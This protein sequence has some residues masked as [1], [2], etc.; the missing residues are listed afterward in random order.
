[1][2]VG[3]SG[4]FLLAE[5]WRQGQR[6][7]RIPMALTDWY[8]HRFRSLYYHEFQQLNFYNNLQGYNNSMIFLLHNIRLYYITNSE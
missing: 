4:L 8:G 2:I 7:F 1:M 3:G 5:P 6:T